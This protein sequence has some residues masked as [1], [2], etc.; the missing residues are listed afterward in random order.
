MRS[1]FALTALALCAL[2]TPARAAVLQL[3]ESLLVDVAELLEGEGRLPTG[4]STALPIA[5]EAG[6]E[7]LGA[8]PGGRTFGLGLQIGAPTALTI[9]FMTGGSAGVVVGIGAGFGYYDRFGVGLSIHAD[10]LFDVA[11]LVKNDTLALT[12]FIGPGLWL[13]LGNGGYG[14]GGFGY[15]YAPAWAYFGLG[16]RMPIGLSLAFQAAPIEVYAEL[17]PAIFVFPG[18]TFG[19]GASLGFRFYL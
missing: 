1:L 15:T 12:A 7:S 3:D 2:A 10:Y 16:V 14:F 6:R 5:L 9:K 19:L 4:A 11:Q 18:V 17:D 8:T 13:A